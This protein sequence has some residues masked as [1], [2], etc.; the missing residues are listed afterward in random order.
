[1][2][3]L[4]L[5]KPTSNFYNMH[6]LLVRADILCKSVFQIVSKFHMSQHREI[7]DKF[8]YTQMWAKFRVWT[9]WI[10][11]VNGQNS[12]NRS[13]RIK[14]KKMSGVIRC[15]QIGWN[16]ERWCDPV[17]PDWMKFR[18]M[19]WSSVTRLDEI[20]KNG[21]IQCDQIRW[22]F[23]KNESKAILKFGSFFWQTFSAEIVL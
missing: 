6:D 12:A 20:S 8:T 7:Y 11:S 14:V 19:V 13:E 1:L 18:K 10:S 2:S 4:I 5:T 15:D 9:F 16:F 23:E 22:N 3:V 21:V 17:W